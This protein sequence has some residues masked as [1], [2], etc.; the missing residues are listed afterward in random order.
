MSGLKWKKI[1][2]TQTGAAYGLYCEKNKV[3]VSLNNLS[4]SIELMAVEWDQIA[5][6]V[7]R[8]TTVDSDKWRELSNVF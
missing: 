5:C 3:K 7:Q 4:S 2:P 8:S 6:K 1:G